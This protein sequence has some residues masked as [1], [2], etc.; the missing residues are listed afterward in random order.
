MTELAPPDW[1]RRYQHITWEEG[2]RMGARQDCYGLVALIFAAEKAIALKDWPRL[3]LTIASTHGLDFTEASFTRD[4]IPIQP[5]FEQPFDAAVIKRPM[6]VEGR[7]KF[8]WWHLG[9]V[10]RPGFIVHIEQ[11][12]GVIETPFR[13]TDVARAAA[14]LP[15]RH[16][17][18]FRHYLLSGANA[19]RSCAAASARETGAA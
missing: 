12:A 16:V 2:G 10:S 17:R 8:G 13:D 9:V 15:T 11:N 3:D 6:T 14:T 1:L 5:G 4:F 19:G 7:Q 18:L